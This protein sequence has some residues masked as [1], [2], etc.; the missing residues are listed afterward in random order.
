MR[1][2]EPEQARVAYKET[3]ERLERAKKTAAVKRGEIDR[4]EREM[5]AL[6]DEVSRKVSAT[7]A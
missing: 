3:S 5:A 2:V 6:N 4:L 7:E 1:E